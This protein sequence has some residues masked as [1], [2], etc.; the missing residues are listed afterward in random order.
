MFLGTTAYMKTPLGL[1]HSKDH[2][3]YIGSVT[4]GKIKV[5]VRT[6]NR[7][8]DKIMKGKFVE[9]TGK[10]VQFLNN[11]PYIMFAKKDQFKELEIPKDESVS[12]SEIIMAHEYAAK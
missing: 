2:S 9:I 11:P 12:L 6:T 5:E 7:D 8:F 10:V 4:D 3:F 1:L